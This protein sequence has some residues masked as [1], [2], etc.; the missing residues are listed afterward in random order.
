MS[1]EFLN[2]ESIGRDEKPRRD[3][4]PV[5]YRVYTVRGVVP[6]F[7]KESKVQRGIETGSLKDVV[8]IESVT[9]FNEA[10]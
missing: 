9:S 10:T 1:V 2:Y 5:L 7:L 8:H 6:G 4:R 3:K